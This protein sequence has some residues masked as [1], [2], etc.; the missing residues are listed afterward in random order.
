MLA[1]I[2]HVGRIVLH[3]TLP[4]GLTGLLVTRGWEVD[5][6]AGVGTAVAVIISIGAEFVGLWLARRES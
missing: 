2:S 5:D 1:A 4:C 3:Y 6:A